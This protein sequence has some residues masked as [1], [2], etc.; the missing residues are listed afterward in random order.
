MVGRLD[1]RAMF[2]LNVSCAV[3]LILVDAW[4]A[5]ASGKSLVAIG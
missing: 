4:S 1:W 3:T 2:A 5:N